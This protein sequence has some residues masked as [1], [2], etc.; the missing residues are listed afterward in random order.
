MDVAVGFVVAVG[1]ADALAVGFVEGAAP[2]FAVAC[3]ACAGESS[4]PV[5]ADVAGGG[6]LL[7]EEAELPGAVT[8]G[9]VAVIDVSGAR[10]GSGSRGRLK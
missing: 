10:G 8:L 3:G 1:F 5:L 9:A 2:V 7:P 4:T 6:A